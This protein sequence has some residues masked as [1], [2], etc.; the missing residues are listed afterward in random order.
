MDFRETCVK[1]W[2][3]FICLRIR[4][5][6]WQP[7]SCEFGNETSSSKKDGKFLWLH[8]RLLISQDENYRMKL[9][10]GPISFSLPDVASVYEWKSVGCLV[11]TACYCQSRTVCVLTLPPWDQIFS[12]ILTGV[13]AR[14]QK[15][16]MHV[17]LHWDLRPNGK[18]PTL[19]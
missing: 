2:N 14:V 7:G 11:V 5:L 4:T 17:D 1:L 19:L 12:S 9:A 10:Q 6:V 8:E 3:I 16:I 13:T 15:L 18:Q